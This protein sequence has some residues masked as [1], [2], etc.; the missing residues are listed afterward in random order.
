MREFLLVCVG[1][2]LGSGAR[3]LVALGMTK[4][5]AGGFPLGTLVVNLVGSFILAALM[6]LEIRGAP[7]RPDLRIALTTGLMG[8]FTTFSAFSH[9][10]VSLMQRDAYALATLNVAVSVLGCLAA[11]ALGYGLARSFTGA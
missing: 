3:Y 5:F 9:E 10:T 6:G 1:G 11:A 8:G 7:L 4:Q 2:G